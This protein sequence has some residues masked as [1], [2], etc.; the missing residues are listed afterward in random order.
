MKDLV[1]Y[2]K[3]EIVTQYKFGLLYATAG[4]TTE[5]DYYSNAHL[6][7]DLIEL[8]VALGNF[9]EL[10]SWEGFNGGLDV[11]GK[12]I[13]GGT[14]L[15]CRFENFYDI[16]FHVA[17]LIP[18]EPNDEQHIGRKRHL[19]NDMV[20]LVFTDSDIPFDPSGFQSHFNRTYSISNGI[21]F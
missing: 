20:I 3:N 6:V 8:M 11:S 7:P 14:S 17:P 9:V 15:F 19:G 21:L 5:T 18:C 12:N 2:E 16:M 13:T 4:Q 10:E 1:A